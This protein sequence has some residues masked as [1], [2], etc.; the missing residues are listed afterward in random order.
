MLILYIFHFKI[1]NHLLSFITIII[2]ERFLY[3]RHFV[4]TILCALKNSDEK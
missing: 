3:R 4:L 2:E 1:S